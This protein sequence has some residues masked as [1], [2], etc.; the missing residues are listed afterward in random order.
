MCFACYYVWSNSPAS[1]C[2]VVGE[3]EY[4]HK[5]LIGAWAWQINCLKRKGRIVALDDRVIEWGVGKN[6][7]TSLLAWHIPFRCVIV[8]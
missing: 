8:S 4:F 7:L 3:V 5:N 1:L 6:P 2:W